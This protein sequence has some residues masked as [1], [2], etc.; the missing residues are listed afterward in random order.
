MIIL[1][2]VC[3]TMYKQPMKSL[4]P[5]NVPMLLKPGDC[6]NIKM[7]PYE[8]RDSHYEDDQMVSRLSYLYNVNPHTWK[9]RL[10]IIPPAQRSCRG[11]ILVSLRP[12][13]RLSAR[14][15]RILCPLCSG[16]S[17]G[18]I[19]FI[20]TYLIKQL[21]KVC[22]VQS[23]LQNLNFWHF[24]KICNVDF[25]LFWLWIW[26]ESLVWVIMVTGGYLR[27]QAF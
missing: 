8:Y 2:E 1:Q 22:H 13:I 25:V 20:F 14:L 7:S 19:H 3:K 4:C 27:T 11:G 24:L 10:F 9:D 17:S 16:Y 5:E 12:S 23:F 21:Q 26:C 18:W 6:L 15:S